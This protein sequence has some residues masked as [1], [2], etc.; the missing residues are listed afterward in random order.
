MPYYP[1]GYV[2]G[3]KPDA[4]RKREHEQAHAVGQFIGGLAEA[5]APKKVRNAKKHIQHR[6]PFRDGHK[7]L[8]KPNGKF[9]KETAPLHK[10]PKRIPWEKEGRNWKRRQKGRE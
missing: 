1:N 3:A 4:A 10:R 6:F 7:V 8:R 2:S 9:A 5:A